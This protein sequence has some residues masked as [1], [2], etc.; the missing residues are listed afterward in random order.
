[1]DR[2]GHVMTSCADSVGS[3]LIKQLVSKRGGSVQEFEGA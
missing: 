3:F 1:M 2:T